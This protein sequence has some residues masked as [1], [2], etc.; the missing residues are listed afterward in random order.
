MHSTRYTTPNTVNGWRRQFWFLG[1]GPPDLSDLARICSNLLLARTLAEVGV[2]LN[3][4][5]VFGVL[6]RGM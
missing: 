1:S 5:Q 6:A 4:G 3:G 2:I